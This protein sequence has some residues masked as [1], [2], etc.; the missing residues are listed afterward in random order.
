MTCIEYLSPK[1]ATYY[2][3][4]IAEMHLVDTLF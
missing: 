2:I 3:I 1:F 4:C